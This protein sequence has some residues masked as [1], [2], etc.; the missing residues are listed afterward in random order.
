MSVPLTV[1]EVRDA[2]RR[3]SAPGDGTPASAPIGRIFHEAFAGLLGALPALAADAGP[4]PGDRRQALVRYAYDRLIGP[5][6]RRSRSAL[7]GRA[8]LVVMLWEAVEELCDWLAGLG[9]VAPVASVEEPLCRELRDP[10]WTDAV[11]VAGVADAVL[12]VPAT[13]RWCV[14]EL[15]IGRAAPEAD[16]AQVLLYR[17]LLESTPGN[18]AADGALALVSFGPARHERLLRPED[19]EPARTPLFDL[20]GRLA[21][22]L[23]E[24]PP[25]GQ[26]RDKGA[27]R[28]EDG[29][30]FVR[31]VAAL[32]EYGVDV[33]PDG[34]PVVGP[35]FIR[36]PVTLGTGVKVSA[37]ERLTSEV[38]VRLGL[39]APP[40]IGIEGRRL[41]VDVQRPDRQAVPFAAVRDGLP[42][43]DGAAGSALL[44]VGV[45]L[46]GALTTADLSRP[47]HAHMLVA[48][49]T[50]SGKSEWLRTALAGLIVGNT[51]ETLR[52]V[53]VDPKRN[54]F[55]WLRDSP[56]LLT[57]IVY[58]DER[59]ADDVLADLAEEMERRYRL[60]E[61][62]GT[63]TLSEHVR[64]TGQ[65]LPR[66]VCV[67]DEYG[68]LVRGDRDGRKRV[69]QQVARLGSKARAAGIHLILA[70]QQPSREI[71][72]GA[73]D[74]NIPARVGL[75]MEKALESRMLL[76]QPGAEALLGH[77]DLL[78]K[79]VGEPV[80]L[81]APLLAPEDRE[82]IGR[83]GT[84]AR[85]GAS[86]LPVGT[87]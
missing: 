57:P 28:P 4:D 66:I 75:R 56:F 73:L 5:R 17:L 29:A 52:L 15:K 49:T 12:R 30:L 3:H 70:T 27:P 63:D 1:R 87:P 16:L 8:E 78:F 6:L 39:D 37:L 82:A 11:R 42:A 81:Q 34:P 74:A 72:K 43:A 20:I 85:T 26:A 47:E 86:P 71:I 76:S 69:E 58:P 21:G 24:A 35:T 83:T 50:G 65:T 64:K 23:P 32:A 13:G 67:C 36:F 45:G 53:L 19:L 51:P 59:P 79:D 33:T 38:R 61:A 25:R 22:V 9:E 14:V 2:L 18:T 40:R 55:T 46:D 68:D 62:S 7:E 84:H 10:G 41:V 44:P 54:A 60:M 48:G 77:G 80:R 31:L